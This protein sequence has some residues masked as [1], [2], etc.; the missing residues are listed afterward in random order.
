MDIGTSAL[1][2]TVGADYN[3]NRA[4]FNQL[5]QLQTDY[6]NSVQPYT[7]QKVY[8]ETSISW[9]DNSSNVSISASQQLQQYKLDQYKHS[10][11][12]TPPDH[13]ELMVKSRQDNSFSQG[14]NNSSQHDIIANLRTRFAGIENK[15]AST[16]VV[17]ASTGSLGQDAGIDFGVSTI[18]SV[19][20][21]GL[22]SLLD[23]P[24]TSVIN[25]LTGEGEVAKQNTALNTEPTLLHNVNSVNDNANVVGNTDTAADTSGGTPIIPNVRS[26]PRKKTDS[27][28]ETG[29]P[30]DDGSEGRSCTQ[31]TLGADG[32]LAVPSAQEALK[33]TRPVELTE[34]GVEKY[35]AALTDKQLEILSSSD[36][37]DF[38]SQGGG[39]HNVSLFDAITAGDIKPSSTGDKI[40]SAAGSIVYVEDAVEGAEVM[41]MLAAGEGASEEGPNGL[42]SAY[43]MVMDAKVA[44]SLNTGL[45]DKQF[46]FV[47]DKNNMVE[48]NMSSYIEMVPEQYRPHLFEVVGRIAPTEADSMDTPSKAIDNANELNEHGE[49]T[50]RAVIHVFATLVDSVIYSGYQSLDRFLQDIQREMKK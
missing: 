3:V 39:K 15:R 10:N 17:N 14:K 23:N 24:N 2:N 29:I 31:L 41:D 43:K 6:V 22:A 46:M 13:F 4:S 48:N 9:G 33:V 37:N 28:V 34:D 1:T 19:G 7:N 45:G 12:R 38:A 44:L 26:N 16:D 8:A 42:G 18:N 50:L 21:G 47:R 35:K 32:R 25:D 20:Q 40:L 30:K 27:C 5:Y 49:P 11:N 36:A